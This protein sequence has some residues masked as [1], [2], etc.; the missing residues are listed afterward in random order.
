MDKQKELFNK[1]LRT[2]VGTTFQKGKS[3]R[4]VVGFTGFMVMYKTKPNS[5]RT[6][7]QNTLEFLKWFERAEAVES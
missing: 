1:L 7:G 2:K 4:T 6:T 3:T 5:K